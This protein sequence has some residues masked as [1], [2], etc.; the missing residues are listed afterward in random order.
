MEINNYWKLLDM[1][2]NIDY[3][4]YFYLKFTQRKKDIEGLQKNKKFGRTVL[5]L[6]SI[7]IEE[8]K[9]I[10]YSYSARCYITFLDEKFHKFIDIYSRDYERSE[11]NLTNSYFNEVGGYRLVDLD[12]SLEDSKKVSEWLADNGATDIYTFPSKTGYSI[13]FYS[14]GKEIIEKYIK[15][16][17][18]T[19]FGIHGMATL[20][21]FIPD[22]EKPL[23]M[24]E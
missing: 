10:C 14:E 3:H 7:D 9:S 20:N 4:G 5:K 23:L 15:T 1:V 17:Y 11:E 24:N 2:D 22:F 13:I 12:G 6:S 16:E 8:I 18:N 19:S 21:L